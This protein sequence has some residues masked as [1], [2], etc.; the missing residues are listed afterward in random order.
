MLVLRV[1]WRAREHVMRIKPVR[2]PVYDPFAEGEVWCRRTG[3]F[4]H[5]GTKAQRGE[6]ANSEVIAAREHKER[7]RGKETGE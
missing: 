1:A 3:E 2:I 5:R 6:A 4:Y 7:K